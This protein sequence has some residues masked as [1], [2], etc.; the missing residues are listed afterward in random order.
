M[1]ESSDGGG[2]LFKLVVFHCRIMYEAIGM[3][4]DWR[5]K[6]KFRLIC[7]FCLPDPSEEKTLSDV[8]KMPGQ[9][10]SSIPTN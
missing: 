7:R 4:I 2:G 9:F 6:G 5:G 8:K 3:K 1:S 10:Y